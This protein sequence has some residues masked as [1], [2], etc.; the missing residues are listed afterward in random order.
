MEAFFSSSPSAVPDLQSGT[1]EIAG[2]T[3][4]SG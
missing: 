4:L 1:K 2:F 3:I